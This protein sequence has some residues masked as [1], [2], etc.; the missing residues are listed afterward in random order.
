M[1]RSCVCSRAHL[2]LRSAMSTSSPGRA[3]GSNGSGS[4][5]K[6]RVL[7][8]PCRRRSMKASGFAAKGAP[9]TTVH[10][11]ATYR[12]VHPIRTNSAAFGKPASTVGGR[13]L[14][15]QTRRVHG[16]KGMAAKTIDG[17]V[18]AAGMRARVAAEVR[19]LSKEHGFVPGLGVVLVGHNPA[20]D[21]YARSKARATV[22]AGMRS[23]DH[24]VPED[25][26]EAELLDLVRYLN[27][28]PAVHGILVQLPLPPHID[29]HGVISAIDPAK[30][31]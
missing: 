24:R 14:K 23:F 21:V 18:I 31:V 12:D 3:A 9:E 16:L 25:I 4:T 11:R 8:P 2:E 1:R 20:S 7:P 5:A 6:R 27:D 22:E 30:D 28:D 29:P 15:T 26:S 10:S 17:R 13:T 19:R